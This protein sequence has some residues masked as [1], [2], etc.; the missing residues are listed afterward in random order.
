MLLLYDATRKT[1]VY[2]IRP[3]SDV[4]ATFKKWKYLVDNEIGKRLK[5]LRYDNGG[6]YYI[7]E[8][9]SCCSYNGIHRVISIF[10]CVKWKLTLVKTWY[11][12]LSVIYVSVP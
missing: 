3:K 1:W 8:S 5:C 2:C 6:E 9:D 4:F 10:E 11:F 12:Y 7:K